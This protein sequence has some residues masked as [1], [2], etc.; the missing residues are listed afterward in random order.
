MKL[1]DLTTAQIRSATT[2]GAAGTPYI[3]GTL[4]DC[5]PD[6][7]HKIRGVFPVDVTNAIRNDDSK[8]WNVLLSSGW[9]LHAPEFCDDCGTPVSRAERCVVGTLPRAVSSANAGE[10]ATLCS[11]CYESL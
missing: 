5:V 7:L 8:A 9:I 2:F 1:S 11:D 3:D 10:S 4:I 6:G